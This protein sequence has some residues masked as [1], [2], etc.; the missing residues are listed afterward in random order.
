ML[1]SAATAIWQFDGFLDPESCAALSA[2]ARDP[3]W[4]LAQ[5]A[6]PDKHPDPAQKGGYCVEVEAESDPRLLE[7]RARLEALAG[8]ESDVCETLR[9]R[10]YLPGEGHRPHLDCYTVED[11]ELL[12]T[13]LLPLRTTPRGG[14]TRFPL[15]DLSFAPAQGR[16]ILWYNH[17]PDGEIDPLSRHEGLPVIEGEKEV[18]LY[19][20]YKDRSFAHIRPE[21]T[22]RVAETD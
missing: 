9:Y 13:A 4:R 22:Y 8:M 11:R 20:F 16:L 3:R 1:R 7:L 10:R 6:A 19:F 18:L 14:E 12:A 2:L 15:A 17:L 5:P 21:V